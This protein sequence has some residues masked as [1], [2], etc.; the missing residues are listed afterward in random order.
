MI[1]KPGR[2]YLCDREEKVGTVFDHNSFNTTLMTSKCVCTRLSWAIHRFASIWSYVSGFSNVKD[3][4]LFIAS[5]R[6]SRYI[7]VG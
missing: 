7:K 4:N 2:L 1:R 5:S 6:C 3:T